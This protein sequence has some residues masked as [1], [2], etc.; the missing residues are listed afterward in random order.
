M[1]LKVPL[2]VYIERNLKNINLLQ[3]VDFNKESKKL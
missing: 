1:T 3:K 2:K